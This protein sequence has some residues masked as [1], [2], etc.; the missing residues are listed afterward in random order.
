MSYK[1][2]SGTTFSEN[3]PKFDK[4]YILVEHEIIE[5]HMKDFIVKDPKT[6]E[7]KS[8]SKNKCFI[9]KE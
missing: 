5:E 8:V 7:A 6:G 4:V 2:V 1:R 9:W 3:D